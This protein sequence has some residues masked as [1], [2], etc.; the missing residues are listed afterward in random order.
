[1]EQQLQ[2]CRQRLQNH[3]RRSDD[4]YPQGLREGGKPPSPGCCAAQRLCFW[5]LTARRTGSQLSANHCCRL[6]SA[7]QAK[8]ETQKNCPAKVPACFSWY[9]RNISPKLSQRSHRHMSKSYLSE[10][11]ASTARSFGTGCRSTQP[12][13]TQISTGASRCHCNT[14]NNE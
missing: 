13:V 12:S 5:R 8:E 10:R 2:K 11:A 9:F 3:V 14:N 7:F 4:W 1:M 6:T